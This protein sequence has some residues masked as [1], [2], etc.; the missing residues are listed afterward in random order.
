MHSLCFTRI[1]L[2][3]E[4]FQVFNATKVVAFVQWGTMKQRQG[5]ML[6][7]KILLHG[8]RGDRNQS[9]LPK[10]EQE[11]KK[12]QPNCGSFSSTK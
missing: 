6:W 9:T 2:T 8:S 3:A 12:D 4:N 11:D 7:P 5:I 10:R 1:L